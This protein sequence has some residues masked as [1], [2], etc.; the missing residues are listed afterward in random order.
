MRDY[1]AVIILQPGASPDKSQEDIQRVKDVIVKNKGVI[2]SEIKWGKRSLAYPVKKKREGYY[3]LV[4]FQA[5]PSAIQP[6]VE[7]YRLLDQLVLRALVVQ[8]DRP[9]VAKVA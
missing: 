4:H 6:I 2:Q 7:A 3:L 5:E 8:R 9:E 1:E